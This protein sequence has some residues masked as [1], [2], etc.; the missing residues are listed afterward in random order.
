VAVI[1]V[2]V[3]LL[4]ALFLDA[5]L[6]TAP[7]SLFICA[8]IFSAWYGG[9]KPGLLAMLLSLLMFKL[10]FIAPVYSLAVHI[11]E[12]P[13][14]LIFTLSALFVVLLSATQRS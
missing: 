8:L 5:H 14:L 7:V 10:F 11:T 3:A 1:S 12:V 2:A 9:I 13:R 6:V 4:I